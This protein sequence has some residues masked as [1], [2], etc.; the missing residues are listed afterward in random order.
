MTGVDVNGTRLTI[1][2]GTVTTKA[3]L[4]W[5]DGRWTGLLFDGSPHLPSAVD[6]GADGTMVAGA[7]AWRHAAGE[8]QR[9]QPAPKRYIRDGTVEV[10]G[11]VVEVLDLVAATLRRV[12]QEAERLAGH[13]VGELR[14]VVPAGWGP[15]RR[16]ALRAAAHRADLPP[17]E[18][19]EAP[20]AVA[21]HLVATGTAVPLGAS[22]LICDYGADLET[23]LLRRT[24]G[25]FDVLATLTD[26]HAGGDQLD[27]DLAGQ[28]AGWAARRTE[29][30]QAGGAAAEPDPVLLRRARAAKEA[31][32]ANDSV[33]VPVPPYPP[34]V[35]TTE[36][37]SAAAAPVLERAAATARQTLAAIEDADAQHPAAV[38]L[39]GGGAHLPA[40]ARLLGERLGTAAAAHADPQFAAVRGAA[41]AGADPATPAATAATESTLRPV[42]RS[43]ALLV[44]GFG[45]L[46]LVG[47][48]YVSA[49]LERQPGLYDPNAYVRANWG[50][51]ALASVFALITCLA[52]ATVLAANIPAT[53]RV[54]GRAAGPGAP[55]GT[56]LLVAVATGLSIA[57]LYAI[58]GSVYFGLP[59]DPFL[60]WTLLPQLPVAVAAVTAAVISARLR[61]PPPQ[62]WD[63]WLAFPISSLLTAGAGA[64]L[65]QISMSAP[66]YPWDETLMNL[67]GRGG[68]LL[69]GIGAA[70]VATRA[71]YRVV[72]A[73]PLGIFTAAIV[74]W[75]A[76]GMLAFI[77]VV[78]V[79]TWWVQC[80][81]KLVQG[82]IRYPRGLPAGV[83]SGDRQQLA[84][85]R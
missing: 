77:Y 48:T 81:W 69:L 22:V 12:A 62:G 3:I 6:V 24:A 35:L 9:V 26:P 63:A 14:L 25:G 36:E 79:T 41:H 71:V 45:S 33:T 64:I 27:R 50:E 78:A 13:R 52:A 59:I 43:V 66:R 46:A 53:M 60:R 65:V 84:S 72:I 58:A 15:R 42:M 56:G 34:V 29:P 61:R 23:T 10:G 55:I 74:S 11:R 2:Y 76:T 4:T 20:V 32:S 68:G 39:V 54:S 5:P 75:P 70:L 38:Y 30:G 73:A 67:A 1:D 16:T 44:P 85:Y 82:P 17:P 18:L 57:G 19:V 83:P 21:Q 31:L 49:R 40:A 28:L 47:H 7:A 51:L 8:P 80:I 37:L